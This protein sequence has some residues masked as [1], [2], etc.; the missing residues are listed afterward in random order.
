MSKVVRVDQLTLTLLVIIGSCWLL[1]S[2]PTIHAATPA[3]IQTAIDKG[4]AYL[5]KT[6]KNGNWEVVQV[7]DPK[8]DSGYDVEN[9]QF[10]GLT[11]VATFALLAAGEDPQDPRLKQ[12]IAF[13][14]KTDSH[15]IYA[16]GMR[17]QIWN[18]I[19]Q[20]ESVKQVLRHD[21]DLLI[22]GI[23]AKQ[24]NTGFYG[25]DATKPGAD[26]D[27]SSSQFGVLGLWA[28][29]QAGVEVPTQVWNAFDAGWRGHQLA[30][31]G[32]SYRQTSDATSLLSMTAAGAATLF[33][34]QDYTH[35]A[36]RLNGNI[37]DPAIDAALK[38]MGEHL[39]EVTTRREYYTLFGVSRVG[40][41]CGY[42]YIGN[43]NWF[44]WG[45]DLIVQSQA[46]EGFWSGG[47]QNDDNVPDTSFSLL[48][49][50]R[51]RAPIVFNNWK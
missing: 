41:A 7:P 40:L 20:D 28:I 18:M 6:Q 47:I 35:F 9:T 13:L 39:P 1:L 15:G 33:I 31:G 22:R 36:P 37:N 50:S 49:L 43:T 2:T 27:H 48:F 11:A 44:A 29:D 38:W 34:T 32:W 45:S 5:Y 8:I 46:A 17:C 26:A 21:R 23:A 25:Y 12:A 19:P 16:L 4:K 14:K 10:G 51:S 24:P 42:K 3:Q 30:D